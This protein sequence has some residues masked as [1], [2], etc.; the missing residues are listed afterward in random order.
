M[1]QKDLPEMVVYAISSAEASG[2]ADSAATGQ[3][4][5][6][7]LAR[8]QSFGV[9]GQPVAQEWSR[10]LSSQ[11]PVSA[12]AEERAEAYEQGAFDTTTK[13]TLASYRDGEAQEAF[14][15]LKRAAGGYADTAL[16]GVET[17]IEPGAVVTG[18]DEALSFVMRFGIQ[19]VEVA[20]QAGAGPQGRDARGLLGGRGAGGGGGSRENRLRAAGKARPAGRLHGSGTGLRPLRS[21][22]GHD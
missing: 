9:P 13:V 3:P 14:A 15:L 19:G 7:P 20:E 17:R 1:E 21:R 16:G 18:G 2:A 6:L 4:A 5:C 12:S 10:V 22:D 8:A 11:V